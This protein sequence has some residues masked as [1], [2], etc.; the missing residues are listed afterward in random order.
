M[1]HFL[2][3]GLKFLLFS[4][5]FY[6]IFI[7][8]WGSLAPS[9]LKPN[10]NY[11]LGSYGHM[12]T[13]LSEVKNYQ[14]IDILFLGSSHAYRGFDPRIFAKY[15]YSS[16]NLGSSAQTPIQT[17]V[18]IDRYL[19]NLNPKTVIY[20]V[21]PRTF[22]TDGVESSV[23]LIA[24]DQNDLHSLEMALEM[25]HIKTYNT[26]IYASIR[27]SLHLDQSY[28]EPRSRNLDKYISGGFVEKEIRYFN[29]KD[30]SVNKIKLNKNQMEVFSDIVKLL[31]DRNIELILVFAPITKAKYSKYT[32]INYF[33][34]IMRNYS[35]YY[36][37]NTS[38]FL[39]DTLH[40]YD[41]HHLNSIGVKRFNNRLIKT[42]KNE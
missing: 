20:E 16:F 17:K 22:A 26:L 1:K 15:G 25:N 35:T 24:N 23:D 34:S 31:K 18:L 4:S 42:L 7:F 5:V 33:D 28:K 12:H 13:R 2:L 9:Y 11:R 36:N 3:N 6:G 27:Q 30:F 19:E 21:Y 41:S 8:V 32:N 37:F 10:I 38:D 40:F 14:N 29:P 39:N